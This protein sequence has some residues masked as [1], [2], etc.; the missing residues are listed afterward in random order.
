VRV[1]VSIGCAVWDAMPPI[2][3]SD[4]DR[5]VAVELLREAITRDRIFPLP[6]HVMA[7]AKAI[8]EQ[9][10]ASAPPNKSVPL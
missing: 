8:L 6:P 7:R 1:L 9:L 2:D 5:A 4:E 10:E 3:L